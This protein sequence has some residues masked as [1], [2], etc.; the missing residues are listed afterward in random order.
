M[1]KIPG[2]YNCYHFGSFDKFSNTVKDLNNTSKYV[3]KAQWLNEVLLKSLT[4]G[5]RKSGA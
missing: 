3:K 1:M 4:L 5:I 2:A